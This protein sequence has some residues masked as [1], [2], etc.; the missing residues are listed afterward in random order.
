MEFANQAAYDG[1]NTHPD[2]V[3]FVQE[4][5]IP[6]IAAFTEIDYVKV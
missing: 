6:E 1:Y 3:R 4:I 5:W 2:H